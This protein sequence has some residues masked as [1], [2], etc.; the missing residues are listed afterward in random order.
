M[1]EQRMFNTI[2]NTVCV[3]QRT[4]RYYTKSKQEILLQDT[5]TARFGM[6]RIYG[7]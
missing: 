1:N 3:L 5:R 7:R 2:E 4:C 6:L